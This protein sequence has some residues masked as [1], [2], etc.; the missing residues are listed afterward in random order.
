[1]PLQGG[2]NEPLNEAIKAA[3]RDDLAQIP[4][5]QIGGM[6]TERRPA[7]EI[8]FDLVNEAEETIDSMKSYLK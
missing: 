8:F 1:M 5:G 4:S 7:R 3:Q 2:L 6:L